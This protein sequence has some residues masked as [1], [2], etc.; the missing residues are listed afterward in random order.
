MQNDVEDYITSP[1]ERWDLLV[2]L[3]SAMDKKM[4]RL[5]LDSHAVALFMV[6]PLPQLVK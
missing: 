5:P 6:A 4:E 3:Q 2:A 1:R